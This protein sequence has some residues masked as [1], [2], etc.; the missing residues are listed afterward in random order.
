[1]LLHGGYWMPGYDLD[2]LDP[3]ADADDPAG[4][5]TWN[6]EY[7]RTGEGGEWPH[8]LT[9]VAL[10]VDRLRAR[11]PRR[12]EVVLLGHSAGGHLAVWAASRTD[13]TPGGP[14]QVRPAAAISLAGVLDLT[15]AA[16]APGRQSR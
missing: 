10:A 6:V 7:R 9:D 1:M 2:Q 12:R 5:A 16:S 4:W 8:P 13:R 14:P 15:R 3:I 11:G